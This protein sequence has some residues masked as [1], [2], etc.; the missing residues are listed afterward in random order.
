MIKSFFSALS[1]ILLVFTLRESTD[2]TP[3]TGVIKSE[4]GQPVA[5]VKVLTYAPLEKR[6]KFLS[7][8]M[9]T[10]RYEVLSDEKGFF[11]L[12]DHGRVVYFMHPD[13]RSATKILSLSVKTI[14]LVME[15]ASASLWKV[16][17]CSAVPDANAR[18]GI[19]FKVLQ[20]AGVQGRKGVR[21]GLDTYSYGYE[22]PDGKFEVM[23]NWQDST[24]DHPSEGW[25]L[26]AKEFTERVWIAGNRVGYDIRGERQDGKVWRFVS[27]RWGAISYQG[28]VKEAAH[29]F[30]Q[31]IDGM[32]FNEEEAKK[33]PD[34]NF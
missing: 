33:Y 25:L 20:P 31:M 10:H 22:M 24:S 14:Q 13:K 18:T 3:L 2:A 1:L 28:N 16:P 11:R 19:A 23:V 15:A 27:Y 6:T 34:E 12:P 21:F 5:K 17:Q 7:V 29:V 26:E 30:D 32:C 8:D 4:T 9:T